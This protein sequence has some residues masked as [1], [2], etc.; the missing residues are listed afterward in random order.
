MKSKHTNIRSR[1]GDS[2]IGLLVATLIFSFIG[3][4]MM[5]L[6]SLNTI[7]S[8]KINARTDNISSAKVALDKIGR[9][10]RMARSI[11]DVQGATRPTSNP[12]S[13]IPNGP[14]TDTFAVHGSTITVSQVSSG[15]ACNTSAAFP[16]VGDPYYGPNGTLNGTIASWPW[17]GSPNNPYRLSGDTCVL[18]VPTFDANGFPN[19]VQNAQT[20]AALDTY[21]FKVVRDNSRPGPTR[22]FQLQMA[23]FP[24]PNGLSNKPSTLSPG[25]PVTILSGLVG[26]L[27]GNQNPAVFQYI[28][29]STN[30]ATT[31][32]DP[33]T[34]QGALNEQ[35]LVLFSGVVANLQILSNSQSAS[36]KASLTSLRSEMYLRNNASAAI[37]GPSPN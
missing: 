36:Q 35:D 6:V 17:G 37:M 24:A 28:N 7:E 12:F 10:I 29:S 31:N 23:V 15:T 16:S 20:L 3:V 26:P 22:W 32:F 14:S 13:D 19:C 27:D 1:S 5:A 21:V 11:G 2:L 34:P 30:T 8:Y 18:Q 25:S 33:A 9:L 4:S